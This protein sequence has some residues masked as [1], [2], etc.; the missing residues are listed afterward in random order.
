MF[1]PFA[2]LGKTFTGSQYPLDD[3][4]DAVAAFSFRKLRSDYTG[5]IVTLK[6][7]FDNSDQ[8]FGLVGDYLD[9][10]SV[11]TFCSAGGGVCSVVTWFNQ[12]RKN[13]DSGSFWDLGGGSFRPDYVNTP[14][15]TPATGSISAI[16]FDAA[17]DTLTLSGLSGTAA[18]FTTSSTEMWVI[19]GD[20]GSSAGAYSLFDG[21]TP[22]GIQWQGG[23]VTGEIIV[24]PSASVTASVDFAVVPTS[25]ILGGVLSNGTE[26][27]AWADGDL[28][29]SASI[30][31]GAGG[32]ISG[33]GGA[34]PGVYRGG[35]HYEYIRWNK[36]LEDTIIEGLM[37]AANQFYDTPNYS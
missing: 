10:G 25:S 8:T 23:P 37:E 35:Y 15:L 27:K 28:Q 11:E 26:F 34:S 17:E 7:T 21:T 22:R 14:D 4:D 3:I 24:Q 20:S 6:R 32:T 29:G 36:K 30:S 31:T 5:S 18:S 13:T 9:T 19:Y 1:S 12:A 2:F 33:Y 16:Q